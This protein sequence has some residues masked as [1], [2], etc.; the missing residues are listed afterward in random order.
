[1]VAAPLL[2][3]LRKKDWRSKRKTR[4]G[5]TGGKNNSGGGSLDGGEDNGSGSRCGGGGGGF[6]DPAPGQWTKGGDEG[7]LAP[8]NRVDAA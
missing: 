6:P 5:P 3:T 1:M 7:V 4:R 2:L 8:P